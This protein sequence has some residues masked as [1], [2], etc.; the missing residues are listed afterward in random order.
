MDED[1]ADDHREECGGS[2]R[3]LLS[4]LHKI[5]KSISSTDDANIEARMDNMYKAGLETAS[6]KEYNSFKWRQVLWTEIARRYEGGDGGAA[7]TH[8][9]SLGTIS[10]CEKLHRMP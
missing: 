3:Q 1:T 10:T 2:A 7:G 4:Y 9:S 8:L 5:A 6:L